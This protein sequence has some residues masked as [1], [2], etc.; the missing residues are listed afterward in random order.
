MLLKE[1]KDVFAWTYKGVKCIPPK[2]VQHRIELDTSIPPAHQVSCKLN[3]N[4]ATTIKHDIDKLLAIGF[5]QLVE[6]AMW[7]SP[8][9]VMTKKNGKPR[10]CVDFI[11]LNKTTK[12]NLYPLPFSNEVLNTVARYEAHSFLDG[13]S[14]Y[15]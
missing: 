8:I 10:I 11:K 4:Y 3:P 13:Y 7:L 15:H 12:K 14:G 5:I 2:L 6:E 1:L 9:M